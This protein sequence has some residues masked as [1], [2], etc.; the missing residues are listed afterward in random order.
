[1]PP[2]EIS[3]RALARFTIEMVG[4]LHDFEERFAEPRVHPRLNFGMARGA[5]R[6]PR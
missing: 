6:R 2:V 3:D 1:L 4:R 5:N